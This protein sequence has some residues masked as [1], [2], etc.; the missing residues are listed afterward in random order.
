MT[1]SHRD[2]VRAALNHE[3][4]DR[5]AID[6]G[7]GPATQIHP[8]AYTRL[9]EY[10]GFPE[11]NREVSH[12]GE[13]QVVMPSEKVLE[14]FDVDC[15]GFYTGE[16]DSSIGYRIDDSSYVD[17]WGVKWNKAGP[18]HP[19]INVL[20]PLQEISEPTLA[21]LDKVEFPVGDD[22]GR[23]R[24]LR[25]QIE[26]AKKTTDCAV[27][28]N[29]PNA[30][31][32][33]G[34]RMR[35]FVELFEDL[36]LNEVFAE[37]LQERITDVLCDIA[38]LALGEVGDLID[39]VSISD[40]L[41]VQNQAYMSTD[42]YRKMVKPHHKRLVDTLHSKTDG[43]VII[44]SDG[45]VRDLLPD[46]IDVG[47]DVINPVQV[48]AVGME[49]EALNRDFGDDLAFL[50][51]IDTQIV[52]PFGTASDVENA[53]R[54]RRNDLGKGGGYLQASVHN[55]QEE[56]PPENIVAMFETAR[57]NT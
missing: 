40:D 29:L 16:S 27:I 22:P 39:A 21:D 35:G 19:F 5:V 6:F 15:R 34:Q 3:E 11:E 26:A 43:K 52:L 25:E 42:L 50:G 12:K 9:L 7:G 47:I 13:G 8:V 44:H 1:I 38:T 18:Q 55:I 17:E 31:F 48:N 36:L 57:D 24:G 51:G 30:N 56:V 2:R 20:G 45:S 23:I 41:G 37:A 32:A 53:V 46:Y 28:L 10:L 33:L 4:T 49:P 54:G 14:Y